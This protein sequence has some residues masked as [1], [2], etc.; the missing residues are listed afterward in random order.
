MSAVSCLPIDGEMTIHRAAELKA[1]LLDALHVQSSAV[2]LDLSHV[3][4]IDSSGI[5]LLLLLQ[6]AAR[7]QQR[8]VFLSAAS[9]P[10]QNVLSVL[11]L[12]GQFAA[13][14]AVAGN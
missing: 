2:E 3:T 6:S 4:E 1:V 14:P 12:Q 11:G 8:E 10:V 13:T 7:A 9:E 5:Q